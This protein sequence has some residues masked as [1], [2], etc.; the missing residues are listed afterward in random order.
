M[1]LSCAPSS[2]WVPRLIFAGFF[3]AGV[4]L[5]WRVSQPPIL[6]HQLL[7][8]GILLL[9][10]EQARMAVVDL[11]EIAAVEETLSVQTHEKT[12]LVGFKQVT[13]STILLE[14]LGFYVAVFG[15]GYGSM[16]V[17]GSQLF[18]NIFASI[19]LDLQSECLIQDCPWFARKDVL[20]ADSL[21]CL[22]VSLWLL[23]IW[24]LWIAISLLILVVLYICLKYIPRWVQVRE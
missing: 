24:A 14:L 21:G 3:P 17:L 10:I 13:I 6:P 9:S 20:I 16:I 12:K 1:P 4:G 8:L 2:R 18:F 7:A 15:L 19:K 5:A 11:Q 22:L 23:N